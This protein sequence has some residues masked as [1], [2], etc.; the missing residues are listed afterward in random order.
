MIVRCA[1]TIWI[2]LLFTT[3]FA[4]SPI[5]E[6]VKQKGGTLDDQGYALCKDKLGD[7]ITA[8]MFRGQVLF[9]TSQT[10]YQLN[11]MGGSDACIFRTDYLGR[12]QWAI[13]IG[14]PG[15]DIAR[16]VTADAAEHIIAAGYFSA[17]AD[18]DPGKDTFH[19]VSQGQKDVFIVRLDAK[20]QLKWACAFGGP[21]A[22]QCN[23]I[24]TDQAGNIYAAGT[25]GDRV[26][27]DPGPDSFF[28]SSK[29]GTDFFL[30]KLDS[31]GKFL[32]CKTTGGLYN[33]AANAIT[34]DL[35]NNILMTGSFDGQTDFDPDPDKN[36]D[37]ISSGYDDVFILK[38]DTS[39]Q[40]LWVKRI[41]AG[42]TDIAYAITA[43]TEK[44]I[45]LTGEFQG[46]V[47][48][49][50]GA[51][52]FNLSSY[53]NSH[54]IFILK[55]TA[56]GGFL[57]AGSLGGETDNDHGYSVSSDADGNI[58]TTGIFT[59]AADLDPGPS[60][61]NFTALGA[62]ETF[63]VKTN[64]MGQLQWAFNLRST[65]FNYGAAILAYSTKAI[66]VTGYFSG[67]CD[68]DPG[69]AEMELNSIGQT[70]IFLL[71]LKDDNNTQ[72]AHTILKEDIRF[73]PVPADK[74]LIIA[75]GSEMVLIE[76]NICG[77]DGR[78]ILRTNTH[79]IDVSGL[80]NGIYFIKINSNRQGSDST[81][82]KKII[83]QHP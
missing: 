76:I 56:S 55:L 32:W 31:S 53:L 74:R 24:A 77:T 72:T 35:D 47:D 18:L 23:A 29:G 38:I 78:E 2:M 66:Y 60:V 59:G 49:D 10:S 67:S 33:D 81:T 6:W 51:G 8:G 42:S 68:F 63:V 58:Y 71:R 11:S 16:T 14:G 62:Y 19:V 43:D 1:A 82:I 4:Q 3:S 5:T 45:I 36:F 13:Q 34:V 44:N 57:W 73:Y 48:L 69:T 12:L 26:D 52:I 20:G 9:D 46:T 64:P 79:E 41:G 30:L 28:V 61:K 80:N 25:F 17:T 22:D 21:G 27:F 65:A 54:D 39:G 40:L 7:I 15:E 37:L 75:P 50:P 70:D 83:I